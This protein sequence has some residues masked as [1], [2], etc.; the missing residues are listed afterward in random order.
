VL[1]VLGGCD[2]QTKTARP[3]PVTIT[4]KPQLPPPGPGRFYVEAGAN[5]LDAD[6][7]EM[8]FSPLDFVRLTTKSRVTTISGCDRAL[9]VSAAQKEVGYADRLQV[10]KNGALQPIDGLGRPPASDP[11]VA[12]DCRILYYQQTSADGALVGELRLW[13][14]AKGTVTTVE[15]GDPD[16]LAGGTWGPGGS[17]AVL[18][19][20][21]DGAKVTVI[22]PDGSR[23][24]LDPK[25]V[26]AGNTQW[27]TTGWLALGELPTGGGDMTGTVFVNPNTGGRQALPGWAPLVWSPD[28]SR[29]LVSKA[30]D[31]TRLGVVEVPDLTVVRDVGSSTVGPIW[32]AVWLAA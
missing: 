24:D 19:R 11:H 27:G 15:T 25:M 23:R 16:L 1:V 10:F 28:G 9:I 8:R 7:Y 29:F 21:P 30:D 2:A 26:N 14:P 32:D 3:Q 13:D 20:G 17:I 18:R 6:L 5:D 12:P 31:R 4:V 22:R